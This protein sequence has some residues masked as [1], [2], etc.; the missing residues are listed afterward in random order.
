MRPR[1]RYIAIM[2]D[3]SGKSVEE[4]KLARFRQS[5]ALR[6][7]T[8]YEKR[9]KNR[10]SGA[11]LG[12]ERLAKRSFLSMIGAKRY[13]DP[14]SNAVSLAER[15]LTE[16]EDALNSKGSVASAAASLGISPSTFR[17]RSNMLSAV[18]SSGLI[19]DEP[20]SPTP[21]RRFYE[22]LLTPWSIT[23]FDAQTREVCVDIHAR[24]GIA[25]LSS[26]IPFA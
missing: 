11:C 24:P 22:G 17:R 25:H 8:S 19:R 5:V 12:T 6:G 21:E 4:C 1:G 3:C 2:V 7:G 10:T 16:L 23:N 9:Q 26:T 18:V 20:A 14:Y 13:T 15:R